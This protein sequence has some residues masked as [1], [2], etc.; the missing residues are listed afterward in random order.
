MSWRSGFPPA[1]ALAVGVLIGVPFALGQEPSGPPPQD[2][3]FARKILMGAIDMNMDAIETMLAPKQVRRRCPLCPRKRGLSA[4][5]ATV[6]L[7]S[8]FY[9]G[10]RSPRRYRPNAFSTICAASLSVPAIR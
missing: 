8:A 9:F 2:T 4:P 1:A 3:I 6:L 10:E 5:V 7:P